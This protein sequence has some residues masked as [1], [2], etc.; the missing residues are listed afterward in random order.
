MR[1]RLLYLTIPIRRD[2]LQEK[3]SASSLPR[4]GDKQAQPT[5]QDPDEPHVDEAVGWLS[6][7]MSADDEVEI[8]SN[9]KTVSKHKTVFLPLLHSPPLLFSLFSP[10]GGNPNS[11][12]HG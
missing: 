3:D 7:L 11:P 8:S 1:R 6:R 4:A 2:A 12:R 5:K 10:I 9:N